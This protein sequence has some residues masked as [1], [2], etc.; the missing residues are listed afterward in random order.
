M[1]INREA[2]R[3]VLEAARRMDDKN[4]TNAFEGNVS[5]KADGLLYITPSGKNKGRLRGDMIAVMDEA[6]NQVAGPLPPSSEYGMHRAMYALREDI[7]GVVH[8]HAPFLTSFAMCGK[9][10]QFPEHAEFTWDHK[11]AE[12]LPYGR[13]GSAA[14][15][16]GAGKILATG[17]NIFLLANHG[18]VA[19]G[20]TVWDAL[21]VLESA[22]SAA[23]IYVISHMLGKPQPLPAGEAELLL[24]L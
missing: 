22:E 19:V 16:A 4:L 21:N 18:V 8:S 24:Q 12:L 15:Y 20:K 2:R 5:V 3:D 13:P 11:F 17:R 7:G 9:P 6:G 23:K 14:M 1:E 10:F